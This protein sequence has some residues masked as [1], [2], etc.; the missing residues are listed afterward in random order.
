MEEANYFLGI[1]LGKL[2]CQASLIDQEER[3]IGQSIRFKQDLSSLRAFLSEI[4]KRL[5]EK[6]ILKIGFE[7]TGHYWLNLKHFFEN[8]GF[9]LI[10]VINPIETKKETGKR[11]RKVKNDRIDSLVI[12]KLIKR[13]TG[14][15][16]Q[17]NERI[18]RLRNLTRFT[19]KLKTQEKFIKRE[20]VNFLERIWPENED[21]F[22][23]IFLKSPIALLKKYFDDKGGLRKLKK[24]DFVNLLRKTSR[25]RIKK[26]KALIILNSIEN[27]LGSWQRDNYSFCQLKMLLANLDLIQSQVKEMKEKI[28]KASEIFGE[29]EIL[30]KIK[31][32]SR[33]LASIIFSEIGDFNRFAKENQVIAFAGLDPSV[34]QSGNYSRIEGNH[35]SKRGPKYLRKA[36]YY[37]AKTAIIYDQE[38]KAYYLRKKAE[39]KHYN[40]IIIAVAAKILERIYRL[41]KQKRLST[42]KISQPIPILSTV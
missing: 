18:W 30:S 11:I 28:E 10:E 33:Y 19:D 38:F 23:Q 4:K 13:K 32:L 5:P 26:E 12:A 27:S 42:L 36:L 24:E 14:N 41:M 3:L 40:W 25:G 35:I 16:Y 37:A 7:S 8:K 20:I 31:G 15:S 17:L 21:Y 6:A 34:Y 9:N 22:K 39:G 1:D 2:F 29:I